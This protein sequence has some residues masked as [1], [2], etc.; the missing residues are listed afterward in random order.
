MIR[1]FTDLGRVCIITLLYITVASCA[2][3]CVSTSEV[4]PIRH[5]F[6]VRS[7]VQIRQETLWQGCETNSET[8]KEECKKAVMRAVS[9]GS[10]IAHSEVDNSISYVLTAGHSCKS[11]H[12][13]PAVVSGVKVTHLGQRFQ[14]VDYNGFKHVGKVMAIDTRF[15]VCLLLVEN[16]YIRPPV[17]RVAKEAPL[18][19]EL[20]YN[21]A[22]PHGIISP[23]MILSFDGYFSGYSPEG[24]AIYSIPTKPGS[25]GSPLTNS[26]NELVG[27][28]FAGYRS[29]ENI[30]VA[31]PLVAIKV[32]LKQSIA[33]A[34][35]ALWSR[36]NKGGDKTSISIIEKYNSLNLKLDQYFHI[37]NMDI[38]GDK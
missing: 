5:K 21:M 36:I 30:G 3:A 6:P 9:S 33:K 17:L 14:I 26:S 7:F 35:M 12:K 18:I 29:M 20:I 25:S 31:S 10:W 32:F 11:T 22:A 37:K 34:E 2:G 28:I 27:T 4:R 1:I 16:V 24:Y 13:P 23:R 19:G 8:K 38:G 15:D